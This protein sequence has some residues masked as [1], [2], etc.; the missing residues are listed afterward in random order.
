[1]TNCRTGLFSRLLLLA[2][3]IAIAAP[4]TGCGRKGSPESSESSTYPYSYPA[5]WPPKEED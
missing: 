3:F 2:L 5:E 1:M 4:L